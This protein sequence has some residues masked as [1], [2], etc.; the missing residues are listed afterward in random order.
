[1]SFGEQIPKA[2]Q[3]NERDEK[4]IEA[5]IDLIRRGASYEITG[6]PS[7]LAD[8]LIKEQAGE[9]YP[10][11]ATYI[12]LNK[13]IA[14]PKEELDEET[15]K[16]LANSTGLLVDNG[17]DQMYFV[18]S[19]GNIANFKFDRNTLKKIRSAKEAAEHD[20]VLHKV[21]NELESIGFKWYMPSHDNQRAML[22]AVYQYRK[23]VS[24]KEKR[25]K[26][27]KFNF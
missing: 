6:M 3:E 27:E 13:T 12:R 25:E 17:N 14:C 16:K 8:E 4:Q 26:H 18:D 23:K 7:D 2:K 5:D 15:S 9:L 19:D 22:E 1:M 10:D 11:L 21:Y 20:D 24:E